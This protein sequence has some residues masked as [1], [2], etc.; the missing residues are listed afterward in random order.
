[1][2]YDSTFSGRSTEYTYATDTYP[3]VM[4][5]EFQTA[6]DMCNIKSGD[7]ILNIPGACVPL[8]KYIPADAKVTYIAYTINENF[9]SLTNMKCVRLDSIPLDSHAIDTIISVASLHH[10]DDTER[11][12][13]YREV[14]RLLKG[15]GK[16][17]IADVLDGS[18]QADWLNN[19]V[20]TYNSCGHI[21]QFWSNEDIRLL[22]ECNFA[23]ETHIKDYTWDFTSRAEMVDYCRNLFGLDLAD[24]NQILDGLNMYL[25]PVYLTD[26]RVS[27]PW[28]LIYFIARPTVHPSSSLSLN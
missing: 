21:A 9:A 1:M 6:V 17:I 22:N 18:P 2:N 28:K 12:D 8:D 10:I 16:F 14:Y 25:K 26:G 3:H 23:V 7:T 4:D 13:M 27:L 24:D 11:K 5:R 15:T 20:N 19:T